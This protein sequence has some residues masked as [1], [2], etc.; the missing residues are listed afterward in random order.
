[1]EKKRINKKL[2][3]EDHKGINNAAKLTKRIVGAVGGLA[4]AT[5]V[6][7]KYGKEI[8]TVSKNFFLRK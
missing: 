8:L 2:N 5:P 4:I 6:I 1:M 3:K 7:K